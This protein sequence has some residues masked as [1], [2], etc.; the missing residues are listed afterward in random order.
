MMKVLSFSLA[1]LLGTIS[2]AG[3]AQAQEQVLGYYMALLGPQDRMNSRGVPLSDARAIVQQDR[4]NF[5]RFG[6]RHADDQYDPWFSSPDQRRAMGPKLQI[7]PGTARIIERQ[8]ALIA[9]TVFGINGRVSR[10]RVEI[11]G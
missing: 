2:V 9:V 8:N 3:P 1:V 4:A 11:P 7:Y 10:I 5:H 6:I